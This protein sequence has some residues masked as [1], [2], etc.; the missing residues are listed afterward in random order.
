[1]SVFY[2][3]ILEILSYIPILLK[4]KILL[5]QEERSSFRNVDSTKMVH[6]Q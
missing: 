6:S 3:L 1:M 2:M 5:N 4:V